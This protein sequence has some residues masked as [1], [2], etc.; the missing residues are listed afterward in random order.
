MVDNHQLQLE[1]QII[2]AL[3]SDNNVTAHFT[4]EY[5]EDDPEIPEGK[6]RTSVYTF[7][8]L[9]HSNFLFRSV[10]GTTTITTLSKIINYINEE[11]KT[12]K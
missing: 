11:M 8:K 5:N 1:S 6:L 4:Y 10:V 12:E 2:E 7:N 3:H 9:R